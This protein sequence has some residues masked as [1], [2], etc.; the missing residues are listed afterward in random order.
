MSYF[1]MKWRHPA[2]RVQAGY[3]QVEVAKLLGV[4]EQTII[5]WENGATAL[6]MEYA[7]KLSELYCIPLAYMDWSREG[8][9][10]PLRERRSELGGLQ[11]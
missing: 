5:R 4:T 6:K 7:Q 10:T 3:T 1:D 9:K 11:E 8:N 2:C